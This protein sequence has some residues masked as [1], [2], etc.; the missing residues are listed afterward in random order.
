M[1]L[2]NLLGIGSKTHQPDRG[3]E[4]R[5]KTPRLGVTT[6]K[7]PAAPR[8]VR[9]YRDK[10]LRC[11]NEVPLVSHLHNRLADQAVGVGLLP[12]FAW[13]ADREFSKEVTNLIRTWSGSPLLFDPAGRRSLKLLQ[14]LA[15]K[16]RCVV[17]EMFVLFRLSGPFGLQVQVLQ[18]GSICGN[19]K[20]FERAGW[21]VSQNP[22]EETDPSKICFVYDGIA[23]NFNDLPIAYRLN[24]GKIYG[25]EMIF[26]VMDPTDDVEVR[27][28]LPLGYQALNYAVDLFDTIA[29]SVAS[30]KFQAMFSFIRRGRNHFAKALKR[31][32]SGRDT[33]VD[34]PPS[35][36]SNELAAG[37]SAGT[38]LP[39][40]IL[41]L[42][43][44]EKIEALPI[45][46]TATNTAA[47]LNEL[48]DLICLAYDVSPD[49]ILRPGTIGATAWRGIMGQL[50]QTTRNN[51]DV[52]IAGLTLAITVRFLSVAEAKG[53]LSKPLPPSFEQYVRIQYPATPSVDYGR[54]VKAQLALREAGLITNKIIQE[55]EGRNGEEVTLDRILEIEEEKKWCEEHGVLYSEFRAN[56]I[57]AQILASSQ[58][59]T[60]EK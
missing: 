58:Q 8:D 42:P 13:P 14:R 41:E 19:Q 35:P 32:L 56:Q 50:D 38:G 51:Q 15:V 11:R 29:H 17:G 2:L 52:C 9:R 21:K 54:D 22:T 20:D 36:D 1:N 25:A 26:H 37:L 23:F 18:A 3:D 12:S 40:A 31:A 33:A 16:Q 48:K 28:G 4:S 49:F 39:G 43:E 57:T 53:L 46:A 24:T 30:S 7:A 34:A 27:R 6:S 5:S 55:G 60:P 44:N 59:T 10:A 47:T 45:T